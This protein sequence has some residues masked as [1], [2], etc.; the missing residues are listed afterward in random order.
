MKIFL[1]ISLA[2][3]VCIYFF[4]V[5]YKTGERNGYARGVIDSINTIDSELKT[6]TSKASFILVQPEP[7]DC[8]YYAK[9][10]NN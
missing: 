4:F 6:D 7:T 10:K 2:I 5:G 1:S 8:K 9:I 3:I